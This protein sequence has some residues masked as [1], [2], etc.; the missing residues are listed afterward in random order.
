MY[1]AAAAA[2][3]AAAAKILHPAK[4]VRF[5]EEELAIVRTRELYFAK[6]QQD[7]FFS[8]GVCILKNYATE[9]GRAEIRGHVDDFLRNWQ[10]EFK[11]TAETFVLG[12]FGAFGT[13][14]NF[15]AP[16]IRALNEMMHVVLQDF[17]LK[18]YRGKAVTSMFNR[19][20]VRYPGTSLSGESA[21]RDNSPDGAYYLGGWLNCGDVVQS[22]ECLPGSQEE[23][24]AAARVVGG[25]DKLSAAELVAYKA[26]RV[27]YKIRPGEMIVF[28]P[29]V[30]AIAAGK[31]THEAP[32]IDARLWHSFCITEVTKIVGKREGDV[33]IVETVLPYSP[34]EVAERLQIPELPSGQECPMYA[35]LHKVNW[36]DRLKEFSSQVREELLDFDGIVERFLGRLAP[37]REIAAVIAKLPLYSDV[38]L[39]RYES[40]SLL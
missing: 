4:R 36:G 40:Y 10:L 11:D 5:E 18:M 29:I 16:P 35:K 19:F 33:A 12:G 25:F 8:D 38:E 28:K 37:S 7:A 27:V 26:K 22:F 15:H 20:G 9:E 21:H 32:K 13:W 23:Y 2:A 39:G 24:S 1:T 3:A 30:H 14:S 17:F 6:M 34:R 31:R